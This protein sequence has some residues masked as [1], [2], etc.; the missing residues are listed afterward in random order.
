MTL[1]KCSD[2]GAQFEGDMKFCAKCGAKLEEVDTMIPKNSESGHVETLQSSG[3]VADEVI[4]PVNSEVKPGR[5]RVLKCNEKVVTLGMTDGSVLEVPSTDLGFKANLND[6]IEIFVNNGNIIYA[7]AAP[8]KEN[9]IVVESDKKANKLVYFLLAFFLG[10]TGIHNFYSGNTVIGI[11]WLIVFG[12]CFLLCLTGFG[13][14]IGL[15]V[16]GVLEVI[17]LIQ[18]IIYVLR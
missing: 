11:I 15:P 5:G 14:F 4:P 7:K 8:P 12:I 18:A 2:C 16:I 3:A 1:K 9:I 6:E 17:A 13:A 10:A